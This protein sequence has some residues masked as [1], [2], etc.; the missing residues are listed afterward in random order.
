[1]YNTAQITLIFFIV[2][3]KIKL[4]SEI[5]VELHTDRGC[6]LVIESVIL[7]ILCGGGQ[8][9]VTVKSRTMSY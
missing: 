8:T 2:L 6:S 5:G 1:M 7:L 4:V 9:Y 3:V